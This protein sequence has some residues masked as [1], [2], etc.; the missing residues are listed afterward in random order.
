MTY[1]RGGTDR[2]RLPH[3]KESKPPGE[4]PDTEGLLRADVLGIR[5]TVSPSD[6]DRLCRIRVIFVASDED[7]DRRLRPSPRDLE[8]RRRRSVCVI[9]KAA[10]TE[11]PLL[12][13]VRQSAAG[14]VLRITIRT[15]GHRRGTFR[16]HDAVTLGQTTP[17]IEC[18]R[19]DHRDD[20][21]N[22]EHR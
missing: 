19:E 7:D 22:H 15:V 16:R 20:D 3:R 11:N 2:A 5:R 8:E 17:A 9:T 4:L 6:R 13:Q 21:H 14:D 1:A 10:V 18:D 12:V